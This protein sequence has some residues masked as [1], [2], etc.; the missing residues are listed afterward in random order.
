M[1]HNIF[2]DY[3]S[4]AYRQFCPLTINTIFDPER[5]LYCPTITLAK[6]FERIKPSPVDVPVAGPSRT[7][8]PKPRGDVTRLTRGGY[9]LAG[10]LGLSREVYQ[11]IRVRH[12]CFY[13][14]I[15]AYSP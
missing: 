8:I 9:T 15:L 12:I 13:Y 1:P 3:H 11:E 14:V 4:R 10:E 6:T 2:A 7:K 5:L